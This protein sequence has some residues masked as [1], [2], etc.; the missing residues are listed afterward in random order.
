MRLIF[1]LISLLWLG[2][3]SCTSVRKPAASQIAVSE[4]AD[5]RQ[6]P[7]QEAAQAQTSTET[8]D[9]P[10]TR[11]DFRAA[12]ALKTLETS[13]PEKRDGLASTNR[14]ILSPELKKP[15]GL[16]KVALKMV[17]KQ[18][19]KAIKKRRPA[20]EGTIL[21]LSPVL[22]FALLAVLA[23]VILLFVAGKSQ[24][25]SLLTVILL[26]G[27]LLVALAAFLDLI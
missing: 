1:L 19:T 11:S 15:L 8:T 5:N 16:S 14:K 12:E 24:F 20:Q 17:E 27:G 25:F 6:Q 2:F 9:L 13:Q 7:I 26:I 21:G 23:G 18:V 22:F 4:S 10:A 3:S